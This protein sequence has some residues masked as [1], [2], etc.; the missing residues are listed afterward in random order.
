MDIVVSFIA[1][2]C[3]YLAGCFCETEIINVLRCLTW[4]MTLISWGIIAKRVITKRKIEKNKR[5]RRIIVAIPCSIFPTYLL[6]AYTLE[7]YLF[8][9][10]I[11]ME[12]LPYAAA[13]VFSVGIGFALGILVCVIHWVYTC[14]LNAEE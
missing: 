7:K 11:G 13:E 9:R 3:F 4:L 5:K 14:N 6:C 10:G 8:Y 1:L 2:I 12:H